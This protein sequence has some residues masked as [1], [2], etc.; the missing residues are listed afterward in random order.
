[1]HIFMTFLCNI[2]SRH[3]LATLT[4]RRLITS[5][6]DVAKQQEK[7]GDGRGETSGWGRVGLGKVGWGE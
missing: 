1:M 4:D 2:V 5:R 7:G 6:A 3:R